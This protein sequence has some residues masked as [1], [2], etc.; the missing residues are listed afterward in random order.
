MVIK[1][2]AT[3]HIP[4]YL[5]ERYGGVKDNTIYTRVGDTN[6]PKDRSASYNEIEKTMAYSFRKRTWITSEEGY[7]V[8]AI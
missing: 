6:T 5:E 1:C 4:Y 3:K 7:Y 8:R 2:K